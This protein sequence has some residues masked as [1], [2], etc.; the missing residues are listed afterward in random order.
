MKA[1]VVIIYEINVIGFPWQM[2]KPM[3]K[4]FSKVVWKSM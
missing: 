4:L 3:L 2:Q 1:N